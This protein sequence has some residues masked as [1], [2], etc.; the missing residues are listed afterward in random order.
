MQWSHVAT[1]KIKINMEKLSNNRFSALV[2][3]LFRVELVIFVVF[4]PM[5]EV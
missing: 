3:L 5:F 1:S 4:V 2:L